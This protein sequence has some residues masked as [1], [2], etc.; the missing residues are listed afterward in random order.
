MPTTSTRIISIGYTGDVTATE[1]LNAASNTVS[2]GTFE[3]KTLASGANTITP[4]TG[5]STPIACT[6]V[7]PAGNVVTLTLK[8]L[9]G[10]TG[11]GLH[12]T[13]PFTVSLATGTTTFVLTTSATLTG[14]RLYWT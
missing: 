7:P 5:G 10:D 4:P 3:I 1:T 2:P 9:T 8:G 12:L 14:I 11:I 13:E 6:V